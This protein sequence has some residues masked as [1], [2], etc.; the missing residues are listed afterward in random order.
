VEV[1]AVAKEWVSFQNILFDFD[2]Y[3][4]RPSEQS[5]VQAVVDFLKQNPNFQV[6]LDGY[7]DPRGSY[8][9]NL[10]LSERRSKSVADAL[11]GAGI[12]RDRIRTA[13]FG[14]RDRNC[15]EMTEECFQKNRRVE[16]FMRA[17]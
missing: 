7:T 6:G 8:E 10:R 13:A 2:K 1:A 11:V 9:Y 14:K 16:V 3:N 5:K 4:I 15:M 17:M 12:A